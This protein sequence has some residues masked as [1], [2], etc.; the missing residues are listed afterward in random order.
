MVDLRD[1]RVDDW[2][3]MSSIWPTTFICILYVY[4][5]KVNHISV[6]SQSAMIISYVRLPALSSWRV[7]SRTTSSGS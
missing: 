7:E 6:V 5:V 1:P 2:F 4:V 3:L